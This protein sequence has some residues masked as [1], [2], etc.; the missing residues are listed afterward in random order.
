MELI[1][2]HAR[3]VVDVLVVVR[4]S[5]AKAS[6]EEKKKN[7]LPNYRVDEGRSQ[8][9][10]VELG[11][12]VADLLGRPQDVH[13]ENSHRLLKSPCSPRSHWNSGALCL[14]E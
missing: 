5:K 6:E 8:L 12:R 11:R 10:L 4:R 1:S 9:A 2:W 7:L 14:H 13:V 3:V